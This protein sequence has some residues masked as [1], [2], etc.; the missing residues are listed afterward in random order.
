MILHSEIIRVTQMGKKSI[1]SNTF[2][3]KQTRVVV[4]LN[5]H[6]WEQFALGARRE[7]FSA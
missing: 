3:L 4:A 1:K 6:F 2:K 7:M 5:N